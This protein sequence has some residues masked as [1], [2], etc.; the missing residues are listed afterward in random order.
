MTAPLLLEVSGLSVDLTDPR[1]AGTLLEDVSFSLARGES[2]GVV[3][4][5]GA[6]KSSL[7]SAILRILPRAA[8]IRAGSSVRLDG[9]ELVSLDDHEMRSRRGRRLAMVF[10]EPLEALDPSMAVADQVAEGLV[11]HRLAGPAE[12]RERAIDLLAR[13]GI[14]DARHAA[15]R[16]PH[17][18]SGGMRQRIV[19][20]GALITGPDLLVADEPTT[21]LDP[22]IQAQVLDLLQELRASGGSALLLISHDLD[23]VAER[24]DR[25]IVLE[26]GRLVESGTASAVANAPLQT[27]PRRAR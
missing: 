16:L 23:V 3:G 1:A 24:C 12:A 26:K 7:A 14:P 20:A 11:V 6:G 13:I 17:E 4:A 25:V 21:A 9:E 27:T 10:Q 5:S 2:V 15:D 18:F 22:T 8:R 19:I